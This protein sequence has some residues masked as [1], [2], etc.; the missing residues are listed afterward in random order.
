M[1]ID[2]IEWIENYLQ[3]K[4]VML[5]DLKDFFTIQNDEEKVKVKEIEGSKYSYTLMNCK[6][7]VSVEKLLKPKTRVKILEVFCEPII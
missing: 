1:N 4:E 2:K 3:G 7:I 5:A 6:F